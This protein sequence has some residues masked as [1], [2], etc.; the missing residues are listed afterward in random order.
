MIRKRY[1]FILICLFLVSG[2]YFALSILRDTRIP[3]VN[4]VEINRIVKETE[5]GFLR[6][7]FLRPEGCPYDYTVTDRAGRL[8]FSSGSLAPQTLEETLKTRGTILDIQDKETVLGKVLIST[9]CTALLETGRKRMTVLAAG[10][11]L[12]L[13]LL[14]TLYVIYLDRK[15]YRPFSRLQS[16]ARHIAMGNLDAP[17]PMDKGHVF[18]VFTESFDMMREQLALARQKEAIANQSKKEL[19]ASLSHDIKTPVTSIKL[20]S[21]L[22][23]VTEKDTPAAGKI[24]TIYSKAGQ[25]DRLITDMLHATLEDLGELKVNTAEKSSATLEPIIRNSDYDGKVDMGPIPGCLLLFD[26]LRL[27]QVIDNIIHNAYKYA[28]TKITVIPELSGDFLRIEF[29]DYGKGAPEEELPKLSCKFYRGSNSRLLEK[30]GSGLGL[31]ISHYLMEQMGG[32]LLYYNRED[33]FSVE[34]AIPLV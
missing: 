24:K 26:P 21:E 30:S 19:V 33:G 25:I 34:I 2:G 32:E 31:Y 12:V 6:E 15:L 4:L 20:V 23:L 29:R 8:L 9:N 11:F 13:P 5:K 28:G 3:D 18:G 7:E 16:F 17:L 27:E 10:M 1:F 14:L 22:L